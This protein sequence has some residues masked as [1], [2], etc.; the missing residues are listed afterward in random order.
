MQKTLFLALFYKKKRCFWEILLSST[1]K[2][3]FFLLEI[4]S[5]SLVSYHTKISWT[6]IIINMVKYAKN[7]IFG[8]FRQKSHLHI[9]VFAFFKDFG[10][11]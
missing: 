9:V 8:N 4:E 5:T 3:G 1:K 11:G 10:F 7:T 6:S 2:L